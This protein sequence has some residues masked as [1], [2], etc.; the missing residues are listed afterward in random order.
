MEEMIRYAYNTNLRAGSSNDLKQLSMKVKEESA[1]RTTFVHQE[2]K[3]D[4]YRRN[5]QL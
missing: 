1:N 4:N 5:I 2:D 3:S